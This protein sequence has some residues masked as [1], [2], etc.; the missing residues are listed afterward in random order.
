MPITLA[1]FRRSTCSHW[2]VFSRSAAQPAD[3]S[4]NEAL[5]PLK[6]NLPF[7]GPCVLSYTEDALICESVI[8][9]LSIPK[10]TGPFG[11]SSPAFWTEKLNHTLSHIDKF[12]TNDCGYFQRLNRN[13][14]ISADYSFHFVSKIQI[15][16]KFNG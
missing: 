14:K 6:C 9:P 7:C 16:K 2:L 10:G 1:V 11:D 4:A 5:A 12:T 13:I 3:T 15:R 8:T